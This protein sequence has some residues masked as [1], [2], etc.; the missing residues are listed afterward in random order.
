MRAPTEKDVLELLVVERMPRVEELP[1][2]R[3]NS[4]P[5][6]PTW[7][8]HCPHPREHRIHAGAREGE[9]P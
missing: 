8:A 4:L 1:P 6:Q 7:C 2:H 5:E 3:F 9:R